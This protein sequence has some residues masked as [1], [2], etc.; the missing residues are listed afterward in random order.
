MKKILS[1]FQRIEN[2]ILII[3]FTIMVAASFAQVVNRNIFKLPIP[4]L[5]EIAI[6]SMIYMVFLGTE[7]GLRD[8]TQISVTT[9]VDKL[10]G[11]ARKIVNIFS[12]LIVVIFSATIFNSS[13]GM[14]QM[15][16]RTG[17]T[18]AALRLPMSVPYAALTISFGIITLV[19]GFTLLTM[20][21][22]FKK[23]NDII[24]EVK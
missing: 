4:W 14:L 6:Y 17:Q 22:E 20:I 9:V 24:E 10:H 1:F 15:Q 2:A 16:I 12:K 21:L 8:G 18:S 19:Q 7:A 5:E 11:K 23:N 13:I 3:A